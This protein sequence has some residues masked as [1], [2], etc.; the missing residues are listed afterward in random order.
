MTPLSC[1]VRVSWRFGQSRVIEVM[2]AIQWPEKTESRWRYVCFYSGK[3]EDRARHRPACPGGA[4]FGNQTVECFSLFA[5]A[6][7]ARAERCLATRE[8]RRASLATARLVRAERCLQTRG[9]RF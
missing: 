4:L 3:K 1:S 2:A 7:L 8:G 6:R 9:R 5:T